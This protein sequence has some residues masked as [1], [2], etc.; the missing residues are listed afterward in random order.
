MGARRRARELS[1]GLLFR[2]EMTQTELTDLESE[3]KLT[4]AL[5]ASAWNM[6]DQELQRLRPEIETFALRIVETY[7]EHQEEIDQ[8]I[9]DLAE[10]WALERMPTVDRNVLRIALTEVLYFDDVPTAASIDEAV[11]L[12]KTYSTDESGKFVNGIL[13]AL[14]RTAV[15]A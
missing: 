6:P 15:S 11:D 14:T 1:L 5:M 13:G 2:L 8:R 4:L 10:G 12:A 7:R 9:A 3:L